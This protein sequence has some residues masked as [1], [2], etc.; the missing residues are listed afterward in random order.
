MAEN[1]VRK[2]FTT[3]LFVLLLLIVTAFLIVIVVMLFSPF[4]NILGLKYYSYNF[5]KIITNASG[6]QPITL[7][8]ISD[9]NFDCNSA[10][11]EIIRDTNVDNGGVRIENY[12]TGFATASA[13]TDFDY[14]VYYTDSNSVLN[15]EVDE[16]DGFLKFS[17]NISITLIVA[18]KID[19][20]LENTKININNTSGSVLIGNAN[21]LEQNEEEIGISSVLDINNI[22]IT[23]SGGEV[24]FRSQLENNFDNIFISTSGSVISN[25]D[26]L[27]VNNSFTINSREGKFN[28]KKVSFVGQD[29][30]SVNISLNIVDGDFDADAL[31]GNI[32]LN[33]RGGYF[34]VNKVEGSVIANNT[35]S[36]MK[37][38]KIEIGTVNGNI[39]LPYANS[40][41]VHILE[42]T[43]D[44]QAYIHSTSGNVKIDA[45]RG[46]AWIET[47]SGD[48][49][50]HSYNDDLE[51]KTT[52]GDINVIYEADTI[53]K[54]L[55]FYSNSGKI[56]VKVKSNL[57]FILRI[58]GNDNKY[59]DDSK[60][61]FQLQ[62]KSFANPLTINNGTKYLTINTDGRVYIGL[63]NLI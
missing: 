19:Y 23:K 27:R 2:G 53:N 6:G 31:S 34:D 21:R 14:K 49:N 54:E 35:L 20:A 61:D 9:I 43:Q 51:I 38:A 8:T 25:V 16:P 56:D 4:K 63:V 1:K 50:I 29:T 62:D 39:S 11:I 60:I 32:D 48:V 46:K 26:N 42:M 36:Q 37:G 41:N 12:S 55:Y 33:L 24:Q 30:E 47:T 3:Y 13:N 18:A 58:Y 7:E 57:A 59:R 52:S 5:D 28:F 17:N 45:L 15:I 44:S 10:T 22:H 40:S